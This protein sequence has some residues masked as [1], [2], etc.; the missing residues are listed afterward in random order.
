MI[1]LCRTG[2]ENVGFIEGTEAEEEFVAELKAEMSRSNLVSL[3]KLLQRPNQGPAVALKS[4]H[5]SLTHLAGSVKKQAG[6]RSCWRA[7]RRWCCGTRW[8]IQ[9][10]ACAGRR[11]RTGGRCGLGRGRS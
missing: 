6:L 3:F 1:R 2:D 9:R 7:W 5:V 4:L 11:C 10:L 8:G